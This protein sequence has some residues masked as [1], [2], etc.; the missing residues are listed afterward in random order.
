MYFS[1]CTLTCS[2]PLIS[3][4]VLSLGHFLPGVPGLDIQVS[5]SSYFNVYLHRVF[6]SFLSFLLLWIFFELHLFVLL[7]IFKNIVRIS[8][9]FSF[10]QNGKWNIIFS[11]VC[12]LHTIT[13]VSCQFSSI[14]TMMYE[15]THHNNSHPLLYKHAFWCRYDCAYHCIFLD[16]LN[17]IISTFH[18]STFSHTISLRHN[19]SINSNLTA[20]RLLR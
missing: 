13:S 9:Q 18:K 16:T 2:T 11:S 19:L 14:V 17:I 6:F 5:V 3:F 15:K 4:E 12:T 1:N 8:L 20:Y 7:S 10:S